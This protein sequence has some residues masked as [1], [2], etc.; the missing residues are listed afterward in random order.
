MLGMLREIWTFHA[1]AR[2]WVCVLG[3]A[4]ALAVVSACGNKGELYLPPPAVPDDE[5]KK[6][7][8]VMAVPQDVSGAPHQLAVQLTN[9][10]R[11]V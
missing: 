3:V 6:K 7:K 2:R 10:Q 9:S 11:N 8:Q 1:G 4:S 5:A